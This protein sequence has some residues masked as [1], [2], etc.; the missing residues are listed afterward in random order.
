MSLTVQ[1]LANLCM[2]SWELQRELGFHMQDEGQFRE[3]ITQMPAIQL[4]MLIE[5]LGLL[6]RTVREIGDTELSMAIK[7]YDPLMHEPRP[8]PVK[9]ADDGE[10]ELCK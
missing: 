2:Y 1:Q 8:K 5:N 10:I 7:P 4:K 9:T 6:F 3:F